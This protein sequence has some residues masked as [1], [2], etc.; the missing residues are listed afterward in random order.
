MLDIDITLSNQIQT[1]ESMQDILNDG[2][3]STI[4]ES[5]ASF[6]GAIAA[7][8][9][10]QRKDPVSKMLR[11]NYTALSMIASGYTMLHI[12]ALGAGNQDLATFTKESLIR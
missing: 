8:L 7:A 3:K 9:D 11:D 4:K 5:L 6:T 2:T 10:T 1:F 12:A